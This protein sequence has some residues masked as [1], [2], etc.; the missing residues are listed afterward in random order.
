M[1]NIHGGAFLSGTAHKS[2]RGPELIID[3]NVVLVTVE[4]RLGVL[5]NITPSPITLILLQPI[6]GN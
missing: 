6:K 2:E 4:F 1:V 5:G 3:K